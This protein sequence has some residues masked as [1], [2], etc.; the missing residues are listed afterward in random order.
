[1]VQRRRRLGHI[2]GMMVRLHPGPLATC[3]DTPT[4][5]ATRLGHRRAA[6]VDECLQVRPLLWVLTKQ[7]LGRQSADHLGLEPGML[8]VRPPPEP[9]ADITSSQSSQECSPPCHG[10][11]RGF[12]SH[13]GRLTTWHGT[14]TG[15][16][17][18][19]KSWCLWVR[20][21]PVLLDYASVGH[22]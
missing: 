18:K 11:D 19:L 2:Q 14:P 9:L 4:G 3:P 17:A 12:K 22:W 10:G 8:W 7:R 13:R 20:L 15:R 16:A 21:P 1:M 6:L 5:R